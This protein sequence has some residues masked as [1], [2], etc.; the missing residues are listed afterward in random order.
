MLMFL[1]VGEQFP[2]GKMVQRLVELQ[3]ERNDMDFHRGKVRVRGDVVDI[4][5]AESESAIRV[6]LFGDEIERIIK[7]EPLTG[8]KRSSHQH[9]VIYPASHYATSPD[10]IPKTVEMI[11]EELQNRL[12]ELH[13]QDKLVEAHR[14]KQRTQFDMEMIQETGS[15]SGTV[16][17]T[18]LTLPT[19]A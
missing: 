13:L 10:H 8:K 19:K 14:L 18:H 2:R 9:Y 4:Y 16:S 15:C 12:S 3:Y 11:S 1:R 7:F 6:E 17:Y 5:L